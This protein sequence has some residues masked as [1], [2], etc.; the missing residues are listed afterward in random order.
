MTKKPAKP[1][2]KKPMKPLSK[3]QT[4]PAAPG[5]ERERRHN[6]TDQ[7]TKDQ[8]ELDEQRERRQMRERDQDKQ[9]PFYIALP[10]G[11]DEDQADELDRVK[12]DALTE[13]ELRTLAH[14]LIRECRRLM[15]Q[16]R[17][18]VDELDAGAASDDRKRFVRGKLPGGKLIATDTLT[19]KFE[20][21]DQDEWNLLPIAR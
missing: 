13:G 6:M 10:E 4:K 12:L 3:K 1:A 7:T 8:G 21:V 14:G 16:Y 17:E 18:L 2:Q 20:E 5:R 9:A 11:A 19:G 15:D